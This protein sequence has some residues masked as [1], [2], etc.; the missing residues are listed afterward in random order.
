[1]MTSCLCL[2]NEGVNSGSDVNGGVDNGL[3]FFSNIDLS[4]F[5]FDSSTRIRALLPGT[6]DGDVTSTSTNC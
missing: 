1:M 4:L 6:L 2:K 3:R 5:T